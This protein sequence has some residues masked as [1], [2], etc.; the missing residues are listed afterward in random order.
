MWSSRRA[1][2]RFAASCAKSSVFLRTSRGVLHSAG[3]GRAVEV[4]LGVTVKEG[5]YVFQRKEA[6]I[7]APGYREGKRF[8]CHEF[9]RC[10][11]RFRADL[12]ADA[13][14]KEARDLAHRGAFE[15][16]RAGGDV[17]FPREGR[18]QQVV[19]QDGDEG[20]ATVDK[21]G[22]CFAG[23]GETDVDGLFD[24]VVGQAL[25]DGGREACGG[26]VPYGFAPR[27]VRP[28]G[29]SGKGLEGKALHVFGPA[30]G[31]HLLVPFGEDLGGL[32]AALGKD[33]LVALGL[34]EG[35]GPLGVDLVN[36]RLRGGVVAKVEGLAR[37]RRA[38]S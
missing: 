5:F 23:I 10:G 27:R 18:F 4:G 22:A 15:G 26:K 19:G 1:S 24:A 21:A 37:A 31:G 7:G 30:Q 14:E 3:D 36:G 28:G 29:E 12:V 34:F 9:V 11:A 8:F 20:V 6:G 32:E 17:R 38:F 16:A 13:K 2:A 35:V 33:S 25:A